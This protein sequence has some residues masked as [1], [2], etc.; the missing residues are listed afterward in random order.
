MK[1]EGFNPATGERI[2]GYE[3]FSGNQ[4]EAALAESRKAFLEWKETSFSHRAALMKKAAA[5]L[6]KPD[7]GFPELMATEMGKPLA[8]G[9]GE[10]EK[11]A[12][13]CEFF[14][15][16]AEGFLKREQG[17]TPFRSFVCYEPIGVLLA[18][19]RSEE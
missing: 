2:Y 4:V 7:G 18:I 14:A 5:L 8:Q 10:I 1:I 6:R 15:D 12:L 16:H 9:K 3:E 17:N 19:M 13:G 11:C